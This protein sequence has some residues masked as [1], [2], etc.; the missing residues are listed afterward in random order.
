M[1]PSKRS[2]HQSLKHT[3]HTPSASTSKTVQIQ[4]LQTT[5][6]STADSGPELFT[7]EDGSYCTDVVVVGIG[8][9]GMNVINEIHQRGVLGISRTVAIDSNDEALDATN[10]DEK[11][12]LDDAED[13]QEFP[14]IGRIN[15]WHHHKEINSAL[16]GGF[17][18]FIVADCQDALGCGA[19]HVVAKL[20]RESGA[21]M[22]VVLIHQDANAGPQVMH[23]PPGKW[24][25][26]IARYAD[27]AIDISVDKSALLRVVRGEDFMPP[28]ND[29]SQVME[30]IK[31]LSMLIN[32]RGLVCIDVEDMR[33]ALTIKNTVTY[34]GYG[35]ASG[36]N[37]AQVAFN[38]V[39]KN[40]KILSALGHATGGI[41][42][43][44]SSG[45]VNLGEVKTV[46]Q[47]VRRHGSDTASYIFGT[48]HD[49]QMPP[50]VIRVG[51]LINS[52]TNT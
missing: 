9:Y 18:V 13:D 43:I 23:S 28:V 52:T 5:G 33:T 11:I 42:W 19:A 6:R 47:L 27:A 35:E 24:Q 41:F 29:L 10:A 36:E 49:Q 31:G 40:S 21:I 17:L 15:A 25:N 2:T 4:T 38:H 37:R 26:L 1:N 8:H 39:I 45:D 46:M 50:G 30:I 48:Y 16:H 12:L 7:M 51:L 14:D 34:F 20:A 32:V 44:G 3:P 22:T